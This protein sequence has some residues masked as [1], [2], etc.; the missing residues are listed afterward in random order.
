MKMNIRLT[1]RGA[2]GYAMGN[3]ARRVTQLESGIRML[4]Y[5]PPASQ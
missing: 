2:D 5:V 4:W 1:L 3:A